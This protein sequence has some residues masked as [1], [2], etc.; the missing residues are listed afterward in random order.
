MKRY[1]NDNIKNSETNYMTLT[2]DLDLTLSLTYDL[3]D[4]RKQ[5]WFKIC[6]LCDVMWRKSVTSYIKQRPR[7][8]C[9]L[10]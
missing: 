4:L 3:D 2:F 9:A 10:L 1:H 6:E 8:E 5:I 7:T